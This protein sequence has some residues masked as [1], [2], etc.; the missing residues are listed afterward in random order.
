MIVNVSEKI[1]AK[2]FIEFSSFQ[3]H[4]ETYIMNIMPILPNIVG[5]DSNRAK[6]PENY[7]LGISITEV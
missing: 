4:H 5:Y 3:D 1:S 2:S 6:T 7:G